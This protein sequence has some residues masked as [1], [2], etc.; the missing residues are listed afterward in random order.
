MVFWFDAG[1]ALKYDITNMSKK[2]NQVLIHQVFVQVEQ[3]NHYLKTLLCVYYS[4]NAN[5]ATKKVLPLMVPTMQHTSC[6]CVQ[7]SGRPSTTWWR[8]ALLSVLEPYYWYLRTSSTMKKWTTRPR[9][10]PNKRGWREAQNV[11]EWLP[12]FQETQDGGLD[13]SRFSVKK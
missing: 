5:P 4:L 9:S 8:I 7:P 6:W 13:L 2:P 11:V 3:L 12:H 10:L 1:E